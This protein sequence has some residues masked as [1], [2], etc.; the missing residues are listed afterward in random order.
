MTTQPVSF[1]ETLKKKLTLQEQGEA[2][3]SF[4]VLG[5]MA[6]IEVPSVLQKKKKMIAQT[7]LETNPRIR[8]VFEKV[9]E[10]EGKYRVEKIRWL[11]GEK[12]PIVSYKEWGCI[13][14]VDPGNVFFNPRLGTERQR[15]AS[16]VKRGQKVVVFFGGIGIY[17]IQIAKHCFP[18]KVTTIE[19][20]P[21]SKKWVNENVKQ[22]KVEKIVHSI[23]RDIRKVKPV[24]EFDHVIMPAPEN[25]NE[26]LSIARKW[27]SKKGGLIHFYTFVSNRNSEKEAKEKVARE[28]GKKGYTITF[29]RKVSDFS[30]SKW[31]VCVGISISSASFK[32][33]KKV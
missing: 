10:H 7:L 1:R 12:S 31:Q 30:S 5:D 18:S 26:F 19:W 17:A 23:T 22:N 2:I 6:L 4:D 20:N 29:I 11:Q 32:K 3:Y 16:Y 9:G 14:H 24:A 15:V 27:I 21:F 13:F 28:L 33:S 8:K 25:A